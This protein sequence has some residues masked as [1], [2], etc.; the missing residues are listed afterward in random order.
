M[1]SAHKFRRRSSNQTQKGAELPV[2]VPGVERVT[3]LPAIIIRLAD[4]SHGHIFLRRGLGH[5]ELIFSILFARR[6]SVSFQESP[7]AANRAAN[8][9]KRTISQLNLDF[10]LEMLFSFGCI[11][12]GLGSS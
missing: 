6:S 3:M 2:G 12:L 10:D 9:E 5:L 4:A 8:P 1:K 7:A 11:V